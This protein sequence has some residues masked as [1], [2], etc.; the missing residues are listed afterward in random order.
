MPEVWEVRSTS[1][2]GYAGA[3]WRR[4]V[5]RVGV[6]LVSGIASLIVSW[7][8]LGRKRS[9]AESVI[10]GLVLSISSWHGGINRI[11]VNGHKVLPF[12]GPECSESAALA[13]LPPLPL[14]G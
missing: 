12:E 9:G 8:L 11:P 4:S 6:A 5:H 3:R 1:W 14:V 13:L 10:E 7:V 2:R